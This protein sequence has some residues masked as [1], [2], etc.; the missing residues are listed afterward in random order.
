MATISV[1]FKDSTTHMG[2]KSA[3]QFIGLKPT[4][5]QSTQ[6]NRSREEPTECRSL[7]ISCINDAMHTHIT[8]MSSEV[9]HKMINACPY[10]QIIN[11][12][13]TIRKL[14]G[15]LTEFTRESYFEQ[16]SSGFHIGFIYSPGKLTTYRLSRTL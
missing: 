14:F 8:L 10:Q 2:K 9:K 6:G 16:G 11:T 13:K 1:I 4:F 5:Q 3:R 12:K 7:I 15:V